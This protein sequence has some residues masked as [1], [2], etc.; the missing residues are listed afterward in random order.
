MNLK[1]WRLETVKK[2]GAE[3]SEEADNNSKR[4]VE[5]RCRDIDNEMSFW[6]TVRLDNLLLHYI[7]SASALSDGAGCVTNVFN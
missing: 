4:D 7:A 3:I 6:A 1:W 5:K 2:Q